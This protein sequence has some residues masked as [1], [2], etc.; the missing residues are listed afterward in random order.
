MSDSNDNSSFCI[1]VTSKHGSNGGHNDVTAISEIFPNAYDAKQP[2]SP[3]VRCN[4]IDNVTLGD[5]RGCL[6][7]DVGA[8]GCPN[9]LWLLGRG[10]PPK[11]PH[12]AVGCHSEGFLSAVRA[13]KSPVI[14]AISRYEPRQDLR[15]MKFDIQSYCASAD[16][17]PVKNLDPKAF[18]THGTLG[19]IESREWLAAAGSI[20]DPVIKAEWQALLNPE[21]ETTFLAFWLESTELLPIF[22]KAIM[23]INTEYFALL[24]HPT[25]PLK[26]DVYSGETHLEANATTA[27]DVVNNPPAQFPAL[28]FA[29]IANAEALTVRVSIPGYQNTHFFTIDADGAITVIASPATFK[30][31]FTLEAS[32]HS[33]ES[34]HALAKQLG[35][36]EEV[37]RGVRILRN[38][39]IL[40]DPYWD[41]NEFGAV[42]NAGNPHLV[43]N[44]HT[45]SMS[46]ERNKQYIQD[47]IPTAAVKH[48]S[49]LSKAWMPVRKLLKLV[50][51]T[52]IIK[53]YTGPKM[54]CKNSGV[55]AWDGPKVIKQLGIQTEAA[56]AAPAPAPMPAAPAPTQA[57]ENTVVA[58]EETEP[59]H[60][61][62][63]TIS[64]IRN[65]PRQ[66]CLEY[67]GKYSLAVD[68]N[69]DALRERIVQHFYPAYAPYSLK[70]LMDY[71][72]THRDQLELLVRENVAHEK[73]RDVTIVLEKLKVLVGFP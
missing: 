58:T 49:N 39:V 25:Q 37:L 43:L 68:G 63:P 16:L 48:T 15:R 31:E 46:A 9:L 32:V 55:L 71:C 30:P 27:I 50:L 62:N 2:D 20:Q 59:T 4:I 57:P 19:V 5:R 33:K 29:C 8:K 21:C 6:Y 36:S 7:Y 35:I 3:C 38:L 17:S 11:K 40:G 66:K 28:K 47:I 67:I 56:S 14:R 44:I 34:D 51:K 12:T 54:P 45:D 23:K 72:L 65:M 61:P 18:L 69:V 60:A 10:G 41:D 70:D 24:T 13:F 52:L 22:Q 64:E 73:S 26:I 42:R 1:R 53:N